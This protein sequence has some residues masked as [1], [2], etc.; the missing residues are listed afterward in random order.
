MALNNKQ[1]LF[2]EE[3]LRTFNA[4]QAALTAGYS[5][6]T[7]YS[8]G[9]RLLKDVEIAE[10]ISQRL[11]ES[12]MSADEVLRRLAEHARGDMGPYLNE[13]GTANLEKMKEVG[14]THLLKKFT[15][16]RVVRTYDDKTEE[17][18]TTSVE[19]YDAQAALGLLGKHHGLFV[20]R[21]EVTGKDGKAIVL[22]VVYDDRIPDTSAETA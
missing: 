8:H 14:Q 7:A 10:A 12:A 22:K 9:A 5:S 21:T 20:D 18:V 15:Q 4:T 11:T 1:A 17:E 6:K 2:I 13:D 3:Y 19:L 16:K